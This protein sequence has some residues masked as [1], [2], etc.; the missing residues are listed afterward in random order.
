[1]LNAGSFTGD[2]VLDGVVNI[3]AVNGTLAPAGGTYRLITYNGD[4]F[5]NNGL[6]IGTVPAGYSQTDF[7]VDTSTP[8]QVNLI[9]AAVPEPTTLGLLGAAACLLG[10]RR[11]RSLRPALI[12]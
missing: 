12:A 9:V 3:N 10:R 8:G 1:V 11:Q 7:T 4:V 2:L 5:T 6:D